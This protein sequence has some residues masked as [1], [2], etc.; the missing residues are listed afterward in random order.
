ML[1]GGRRH[2]EGTLYFGGV[3]FFAFA[4]LLSFE[5]FQSSSCMGS[6]YYFFILLLLQREWIK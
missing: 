4:T 3:L 1:G 2:S 6:H 5:M